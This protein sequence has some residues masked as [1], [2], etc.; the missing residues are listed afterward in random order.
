MKARL[1]FLLILF[2]GTV[3]I[4]RERFMAS[5]G[6][7]N[8][9]F[10]ALGESIPEL[11]PGP[12]WVEDRF[13]PS[14]LLPK[15]YLLYVTK[16]NESPSLSIYLGYYPG[17]IFLGEQPHDPEVCYQAQ[18]WELAKERQAEAVPM[19]DGR[20]AFVQRLEVAYGEEQREVVF[21]KQE[22][23]RLPEREE[24][25]F[26]A[27]G[28]DL[29]G[30]MGRGRRDYA[31]VRIESDPGFLPRPL[32]DAWKGQIKDLILRVASCFEE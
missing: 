27:L 21:W 16:E 23:G 25:G 18:G 5:T 22:P 4:L 31:W 20:V 32:N 8:F 14:P 11:F 26:V 12:K 1:L 30:R 3:M 7:A 2:L 9:D 13:Q 10:T 24:S 15:D 28:R 17:I 6:E 29:A 19:G